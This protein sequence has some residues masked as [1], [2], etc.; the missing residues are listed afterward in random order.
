LAV[1]RLDIPQDFVAL[2]G[3]PRPGDRDYWTDVVIVPDGDVPT[4]HGD[5]ITMNADI[6]AKMIEAFEA[7]GADIAVDV[8]HAMLNDGRDDAPA[9]G[10]VKALRYKP[11]AGLLGDIAWTDRGGEL[12]R[13]QAYKYLSPVLERPKGATD[14]DRLHSV[15]LT[16]RPA[17][18]YAPVLKA[19][20]EN[21]IQQ[22]KRA[23]ADA[24]EE[25]APQGATDFGMIVGEI[26]AKLDISHEEGASVEAMLNSILKKVSGS[27]GEGEGSEEAAESM[28][29]IGEV[30]K[31]AADAKPAD[32]VTALKEHVAGSP[33]P[34]EVKKLSE[35][36][37]TLLKEKE[38][39]A[40]EAAIA[41]Y[42]EAGKI[43]PN[44]EK[45][46]KL[47]RD[48]AGSNLARFHEWMEEAPEVVPQGQI[49][50]GE[51]AAPAATDR[52]SVI[53]KARKER[54]QEKAANKALIC[55]EVAW[56][57]ESLR[58]AE[59]EALTKDE[60]RELGLKVG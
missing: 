24:P 22:E 9:M 40:V 58:E 4:S 36:V 23:M 56:V 51:H 33:E 11:G 25:G 19:A 8:E 6:A 52:K 45:Q 28:R 27:S 12:V 43:N 26:A 14:F 31:C 7:Q 47:C 42:I 15:A 46:V 50:S 53:A 21:I 49:T 44:N 54:A 10:W 20:S 16:H 39:A 55:S 41:Q 38:T 37:A 17:I 34:G 48:L 13:S 5:S 3:E 2:T 32:I 57:N 29:Q 1:L 30:L 59:M 60:T 35:Q 18:R